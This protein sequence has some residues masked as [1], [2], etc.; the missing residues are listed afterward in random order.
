MDMAVRRR[1]P[2]STKEVRRQLK[3]AIDYVDE[4][5]DAWNSIKREMSP[6]AVKELARLGRTILEK[7]EVNIYKIRDTLERTYLDPALYRDREHVAKL[8]E[9]AKAVNSYVESKV[10]SMIDAMLAKIDKAMD[11]VDDVMRELESS[12]GRE[13]STERRLVERAASI[14]GL[15]KGIKEKIEESKHT[16]FYDATV[17]GIIEMLG[18]VVYNLELM[19]GLRLRPREEIEEMGPPYDKLLELYDEVA[20]LYE[21]LKF[22]DYI[23]ASVAMIVS[24]VYEIEKAFDE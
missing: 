6:R 7:I 15:I 23:Y 24:H 21:A 4:E 18:G 16:E 14:R 13:S 19:I 17:Y 20:P 9:M 1:R 12:Q 10:K 3:K 8:V 22:L 5:L 2:D 11:V